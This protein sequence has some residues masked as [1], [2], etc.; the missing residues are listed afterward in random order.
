MKI[1][2][3]LMFF[4]LFSIS[5]CSTTNKNENILIDTTQEKLS[6]QAPK[7]H[8]DTLTDP[9]HYYY[10][11]HLP[12]RQVGQLILNDSIIP[13][14]NKITFNCM[15]SLSSKNAN[16]RNYYFPVFLK[17]LD[18]SDGALGE[19]I[20]QYAMTYIEKYPKEFA[21]KSK[22]ITNEQFKSWAYH[23][24]YELYF[25]YAT[26]KKAKRWISSM[27]K[28]CSNCDTTQLKRLEEFNKLVTVAIKDNYEE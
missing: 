28:N 19:A 5:S 13:S 4:S 6:Q 12:L 18:K 26:D 9:Y 14:D 27:I 3:I 25:T 22:S 1:Q 21:E 10:L 20:G 2:F 17:I 23:T 7:L 11:S 15:D 16:T 8:Q 24:G